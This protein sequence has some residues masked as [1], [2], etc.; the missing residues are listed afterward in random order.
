[1]PSALGQASEPVRSAP[2]LYVWCGYSWECSDSDELAVS[3]L[4][5]ISFSK[6]FL[7]GAAGIFLSVLTVSYCWEGKL[8]PPN[9]TRRVVME[10]GA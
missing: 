8:I 7:A 1:M 5:N 9:C 4:K 2:D 6:C 10:M 3:Y